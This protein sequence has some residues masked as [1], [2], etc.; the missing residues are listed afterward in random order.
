MPVRIIFLK[1]IDKNSNLFISNEKDVSDVPFENI[2]TI[3]PDPILQNRGICTY[4][5]FDHRIDIFEK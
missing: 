3:L 5:N 4:Y 2:I 1:M